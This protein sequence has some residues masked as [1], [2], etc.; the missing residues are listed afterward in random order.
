MKG[1]DLL[2]AVVGGQGCHCI[3]GMDVGNA[4]WRSNNKG[5]VYKDALG[6]P[7][8]A[9][10]RGLGARSVGAARLSDVVEKEC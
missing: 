10:E 4:A 3:M 8:L 1:T 7:N 2:T 6:R 5:E 9:A